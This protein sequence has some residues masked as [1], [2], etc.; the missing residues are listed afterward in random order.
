M[1]NIKLIQSIGNVAARNIEGKY[2]SLQVK[3]FAMKGPGEMRVFIADKHDT[4][5]KTG[6]LYD[7]GELPPQP[8]PIIIKNMLALLEERI[9]M[10]VKQF[11]GIQ[12]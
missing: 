10:Q 5:G 12:T 4:S 11:L 3:F 8:D 1:D 9:E 2:R 7:L 6:R